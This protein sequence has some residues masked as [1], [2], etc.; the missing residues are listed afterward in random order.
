MYENDA[1]ELLP[2]EADREGTDPRYVPADTSARQPADG[3]AAAYDADGAAA[4]DVPPPPAD[5]PD[6]RLRRR[7]IRRFE[8]WL[9]EVLDDEAPPEGLDAEI[10]AELQSPQAPGTDAPGESP[11]DLGSLWSAMTA[12]AQ[13][14]KLQGRTFK[15]LHDSLES[16]PES[17]RGVV[18]AHGEALAA[19]R[20]AAGQLGEL[21]QEQLRQAGEAARQEAETKLVNVLLDVRDRLVRGAEGAGCLLAEARTHA[22][23]LLGRLLGRGRRAGRVLAAAEALLDGCN[24]GLA[25]LDEALAALGVAETACEGRPFDP[26]CMMAAAVERTADAPEGTVV[27]V[28]RAG[29]QWRG[30]VHRLAEVKVARRPAEGEG[31]PPRQESDGHER[32]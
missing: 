30:R 9:D 18:L 29:Y 21:R 11:E 13:E 6:A 12:L 10:L 19:V 32:T 7:I 8:A 14:T 31:D 27:E 5:D 26:R 17:V 4:G 28:Y 23:G 25:R 20:D 16:L 22:P 24:L 3:E 15:Q 2:E 1:K